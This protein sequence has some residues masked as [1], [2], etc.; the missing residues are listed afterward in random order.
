MNIPSESI[1]RQ[2]QKAAEMKF[3]RQQLNVTWGTDK[4]RDKD[5]NWRENIQ[6]VE[7]D[8]LKFAESYRL[9]EDETDWQGE[10][11]E[12]GKWV[13]GPMAGNGKITQWWRW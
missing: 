4:F 13:E 6:L 8:M 10:I 3:L 7:E 1:E 2:K 11:A 5:G 12:G 9:K